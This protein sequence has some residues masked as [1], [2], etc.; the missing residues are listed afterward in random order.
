MVYIKRVGTGDLETEIALRLTG[1]PLFS[2]PRNH[3]VPVLDVIQDDVDPTVSY[4]VMP[5]LRL[6]DNPEFEYVEEVV[7]FVNQ[8]LDV[9][10]LPTT[11]VCVVLILA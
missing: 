10:D 8:I 4:L 6:M 3:C 7:D 5:F 2:D 9:R 1:G 11:L